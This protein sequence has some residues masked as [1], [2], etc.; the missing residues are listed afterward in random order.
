VAAREAVAYNTATHAEKLA[1]VV[2]PALI[3]AHPDDTVRAIGDV[4]N[5]CENG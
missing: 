2:H 5:G 3:M 4:V 1:L